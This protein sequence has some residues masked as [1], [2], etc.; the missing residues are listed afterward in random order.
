MSDTSPKE[1]TGMAQPPLDAR[2]TPGP[3]AALPDDVEPEE[4]GRRR[5]LAIILAAVVL[6]VMAI[7][8]GKTFWHNLWH[9]S[10][11]NAFI[12]GTV[13]QVSP[14]LAGQVLRVLVRDNQH[15]L[16][17]ELL[18]EIDPH[19]YQN[20]LDQARAALESARARRQAAE[21]DLASISKSAPGDLAERQGT[22]EA[23]QAAVESAQAR[24]VAA[25][26][27][28]VQAYAHQAAAEANVARAQADA[29]RTAADLERY[30]NLFAS[31]GITASQRD[32][33]AATATSSAAG[34]QV[35]QAQQVEAQAGVEAAQQ[36]RFLAQAQVREAEGRLAEAQGTLAAAGVVAERIA[37]A[38]AQADLAGADVAQLFALAQQAEL[39]LSYTRIQAAQAGTI[40]KKSVEVGNFVRPGQALLALV[41]DD[42]WVVA[43]FK[44][45]QLA[46]M[47]PG[48]PVKIRIDAYP[49]L[50]L[51]GKVDSIQEGTGAR[52]SLL[53]AEN[54]TGNYVKIVQRVPV[55]IV[56]DQAL[57]TE[58]PL[59]LGMSVV[60]DVKVK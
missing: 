15:V 43:N 10:T 5:R 9:E 50:V 37:K 53:P 45:N 29:T 30:E 60:P 46:D 6:G 52:F 34:L 8:G 20:R 44:E 31:D 22:V 47:K 32:Q 7:W 41:G 38:K 13:V 1:P 2:G 4:N 56:F 27:L 36:N 28:L 11:D 51:S 14:R 57:P 42:K 21:A 17:G 12:E 24:V 26:S 35:A 58:Q 23:A 48:Q 54:A 49:G 55:K 3:A 39:D 18:V 16:P 40:T 59:S 25:E 33:Y 19:D